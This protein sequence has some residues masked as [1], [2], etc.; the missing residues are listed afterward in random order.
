MGINLNKKVNNFDN[1]RERS[2]SSSS[3]TSRSTSVESKTSFIPYYERIVIQNNFSE[4][5]FRELI[6]YSQLSYNNQC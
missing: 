4:E 6:N 2:P 5:E 3:V 1:A